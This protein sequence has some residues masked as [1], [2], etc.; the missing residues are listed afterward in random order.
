MSTDIAIKPPPTEPVTAPPEE[1]PVERRSRRIQIKRIHLAGALGLGI[2]AALP[3]PFG[4]FGLYIGAYA[5]IYAIIGLSVIIVTG[6]AGLISL[7]PYSFAGIGAIVA[8]VAMASW[9]WP[10]WLT[11]PL[12]ALATVPVS[13][14]VGISSVRLRGLYLRSRR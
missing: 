4:D 14:I 10:F 12:A 7:M 1:P 5:A 11:I 9:G 3:V 2:L 6:Y 8:S 13:I